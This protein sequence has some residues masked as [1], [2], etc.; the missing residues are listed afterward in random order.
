ML[1][2]RTPM[3]SVNNLIRRI[4]SLAVQFRHSLWFWALLCAVVFAWTIGPSDF[5]IGGDGKWTQVLIKKYFNFTSPLEVNAL[6]PLEGNFSQFFPLN[7]WLNPAVIQFYIFPFETAKFTSMITFL[8]ILALAM[9]VLA[10]QLGMDRISAAIAAQ[11]SAWC[12][13]HFAFLSGI[14]FIYF[15]NP[16]V[17]ITVSLYI[18][19]MVL[20]LR[21][22]P[23]ASPGR[24][25]Q[26]GIYATALMGVVVFNDP[27]TMGLI[28]F[29]IAPCFLAAIL[30]GGGNSQSI[31]HRLAVLGIAAGLL[32]AA[33]IV[34]YVLAL[35]YHSYRYFFR[36]EFPRPQIPAYASMLFF[37]KAG[38]T[39][40][41]IS[42]TGLILGSAYT[43]GP[44]LVAVLIGIAATIGAFGSGLIYLFSD[45]HWWLPLP[46]YIQFYSFPFVIIGA[47]AGYAGCWKI[48][49]L[50]L[51]AFQNFSLVMRFVCLFVIPGILIY[52]AIRLPSIAEAFVDRP[53]ISE[54]FK[55]DLAI[56]PG[57]A[58]NGS[59]YTVFRGYREQL[60]YYTLWDE[61]IPTHNENSQ[62]A[63]PLWWYMTF[64]VMHARDP[65]MSARPSLSIPPGHWNAGLSAAFGIR[66]IMLPAEAK[67]ADI[68][69]ANASAIKEVADR[70]LAEYGIDRPLPLKAIAAAAGQGYENFSWI[71]YELPDP[72]YGQYSPTLVK[73]ASEEKEYRRLFSQPGFDWRRD[74]VL[75]MDPGPLTVATSGSVIV[76]RGHLKVK[77]QGGG[78][79]SLVL[80]PV[81]YSNC[82]RVSGSGAPQLVR[83]NMYFAALT[84]SKETEARIDFDFGFTNPSCR[85]ADIA[86]LRRLRIPETAEPANADANPFVLRRISDIPL[87][88]EQL[89]DAYKAIP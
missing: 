47:V 16:T 65:R 75:E 38:S 6:N 17:V 31:W 29:C 55:Q 48:V 67:A 35:D 85:R 37:L 82:L 15:L 3:L 19:L 41:L 52:G 63:T 10:R 49:R 45:F 86:D 40:L 46:I 73:L 8:S 60:T 27:M 2:P 72:N 66:Y 83:A 78:G 14:F 77:A 1:E 24:I 79:R 20:L 11:C 32:L 36:T 44:T 12:F 87:R 64:K 30:F 88:W 23:G 9:Y 42:I 59:V 51:P 61:Q 56:V 43:R 54:L 81:Q 80:L 13:P 5:Y 89:R 84:F 33:G 4:G 50:R 22:G 68:P 58:W 57:S 21:L 74:V 18:M 76:Q 28:G 62:T 34:Q 69:R 70:T 7:A 53:L 71:V 25:L 26:F 39:T